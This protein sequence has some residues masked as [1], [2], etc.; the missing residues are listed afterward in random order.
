MTFDP[1]GSFRESAPLLDAATLA[2]RAFL[3]TLPKVPDG[4]LTRVYLHQ[5]AQEYGCADAAYHA[6]VSLRGG[7]WQIVP[8]HDV[9]TNARSTFSEVNYAPHTYHRNTGAVAIAVDGLI[10]S[11][12][13]QNDFGSEPLQM[14][15]IE[16][17]CAGAAAFCMAFGI[18]S[19]GLSYDADP[20]YGEPTILTHGEAANIVGAPP[21]Y[22][23]YG[24]PPIGTLERW[25]LTTLVPVPAGVML[26]DAHAKI[27]GDELRGRIHYYA[28]ALRAA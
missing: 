8:S 14:H 5:S 18:D 21:A 23:P 22:T 24:L 13:S 26:S 1:R 10:G 19:G 11:Q 15:E 25:D 3:E 6:V 28:A 7:I 9:R 4:D 17:L 16:H 27:V 2:G 12:V 20:Y